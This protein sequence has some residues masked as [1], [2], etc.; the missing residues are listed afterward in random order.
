MLVEKLQTAQNLPEIQEAT[1]ILFDPKENLSSWK[2]KWNRLTARWFPLSPL[3][4][5]GMRGILPPLIFSDGV[6]TPAELMVPRC[7][8]G[9]H[10]R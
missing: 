3:G 7:A 10:R 8:F 9:T 1:E 2:I 6:N 4:H 5:C